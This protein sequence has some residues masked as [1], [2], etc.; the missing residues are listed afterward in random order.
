MGFGA[1][2]SGPSEVE[3]DTAT[4]GTLVAFAVVG[5]AAAALM[6]GSV[7]CLL[8]CGSQWPWTK[9]MV[10]PGLLLEATAAS[11]QPATCALA[12]GSGPPLP[13]R[14]CLQHIA[15]PYSMN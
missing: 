13:C 2:V 11:S 4:A 1:V 14:E 15:A 10:V 3:I 8:A 7:H 9:S 12:Q 5:L 6:T